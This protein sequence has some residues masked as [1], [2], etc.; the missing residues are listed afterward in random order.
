MQI[1]LAE[2]LELKQR[3][4]MSNKI[5]IGL[6]LTAPSYYEDFTEHNRV[7]AMIQTRITSG[8]PIYVRFHDSRRQ[9]SIGLL[10]NI[11]VNKIT[12]RTDVYYFN[13]IEIEWTG[14]SNKVK[15]H[16]SEIEILEHYAGPTVW[17]WEQTV[18]SPVVIPTIK[19]HLDAE[20]AIDD[21]VSFVSRKYGRVK[22]HF[23]NVTRV[24]ESG[25]VWVKTLKLRDQDTAA[26]EVKVHDTDTIVK[27]GKDLMDRLILARMSTQ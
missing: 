3:G 6:S 27:I 20:V 17:A 7:A 18:K 15:P 13:D 16:S 4:L 11:T 12:F 2:L 22:L 26:Q 19:D 10:K 1:E 23:G 5:S 24:T 9:G 21:F 8:D 25:R 14:R